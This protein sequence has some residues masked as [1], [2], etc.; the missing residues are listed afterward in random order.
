M[1]VYQTL[2]NQKNKFKKV[3]YK[4]IE[5]LTKKTKD[6]DFIWVDWENREMYNI[7]NEPKKIPL[8]SKGS[9]MLQYKDDGVTS[10]RLFIEGWVENN[11][12]FIFN[13][14]CEN[15]NED[16]SDLI[17]L[18]EVHTQTKLVNEQS[19]TSF[20]SNQLN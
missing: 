12:E 9:T 7:I 10:Q 13:D 17:S 19:S 1:I 6:L 4:Q 8:R 20:S 18:I 3:T 15:C 16:I 5:D 2:N 14:D 11:P